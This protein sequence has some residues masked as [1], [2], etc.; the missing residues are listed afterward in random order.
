[1]KVKYLV[2]VWFLIFY[3]CSESVENQSSDNVSADN[4]KEIL[5]YAK[6]FEIEYIDSIRHITIHDPWQGA[7]SIEYKFALV[8]K[9][10]DIKNLNKNWTVIKTPVSRVVCLSTTHI[11]FIDIFNETN[12]II[13]VSGSKYVNNQIVREGIE[14]KEVFDVGFDNSLN[15][16][17]IVSL[18]PDLVITYG[19]G[20]QVASYNQKLNDLGIKTIIIAEYLENHP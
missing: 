3:S 8:N 9:G 18:D 11:A 5:K 17:L 12:T 4:R 13:G 20:S 6:G 19:V 16:E 10:D 14:N 2:F 1:M 7:K 15:F